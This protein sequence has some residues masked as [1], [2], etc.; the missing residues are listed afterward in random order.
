MMAI[1]E[2]A[3]GSIASSVNVTVLP[4]S[5]STTAGANGS[6]A[7]D[8]SGV[9]PRGDVVAVRKNGAVFTL[10]VSNLPE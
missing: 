1:S 9:V 8:I 10:H 6:T 5:Y 4:F 7:L 2:H 3:S